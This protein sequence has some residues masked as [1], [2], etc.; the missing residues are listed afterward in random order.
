MRAVRLS[1]IQV[2][3]TPP[4]ALMVVDQA[5]AYKVRGTA[6]R[7]LGEYEDAIHDLFNG[8]KVD[9]DEQTDQIIKSIKDRV[10]SIVAVS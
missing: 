3:Y 9:F 10:D 7:H 8:N 5:K 2:G 6:R 1:S 4:A